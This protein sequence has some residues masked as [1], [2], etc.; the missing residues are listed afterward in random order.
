M[1]TA[2]DVAPTRETG[3][4]IMKRR[5]WA[6]ADIKILSLNGL[7]AILKDFSEKNRIVRLVG[8]VQMRREVQALK[9]LDGLA[10]VPSYLG[11]HPPCGLL[12]EPMKGVPINQWRG[13]SRKQ[14][15]AMFRRL[16][17]LVAAVHSRMVVHLDLRKYDNILVA[18]AGVPSLIDF[19]ASVCFKP[20]GLMA[21]LFFPMFRAIDRAG[22]L[23][24][25]EQ[26]C[27]EAM[28]DGEIR[29]LRRMTRLR[30]LWIFN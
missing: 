3:V 18:D 10:G 30:R 9:R 13:G 16:D 12:L 27:P 21:R 22:M 14:A 4:T 8:R 17:H 6:K 1:T 15:V 20:G 26:S 19:N 11:M 29:L 25:K 5:G 7:Q 24:W 23:K 28:T 2:V